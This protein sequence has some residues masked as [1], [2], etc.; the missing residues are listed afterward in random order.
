[1]AFTNAEVSTVLASLSLLPVL[2]SATSGPLVSSMLYPWLGAAPPPA[3][4]AA[5]PARR[6]LG[7][8]LG[9]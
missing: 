7:G 4:E 3:L 5:A 8:V 1:M 6:V 2:P 9:G